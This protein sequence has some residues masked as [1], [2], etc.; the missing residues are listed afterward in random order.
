MKVNFHEGTI[1]SKAVVELI[2][3]ESNNRLHL[4]M[5]LLSGF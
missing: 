3:F 5:V 1:L 4:T 2:S